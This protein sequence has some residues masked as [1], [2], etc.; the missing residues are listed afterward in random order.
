LHNC[1]FSL[2]KIITQWDILHVIIIIIIIIIIIHII[3]DIDIVMY[4]PHQRIAWAARKGR[5][6]RDTGP[7]WTAWHF[8]FQR[9]PWLTRTASIKVQ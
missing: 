2:R 7:R 8:R 3:L 6:S 5:K 1:A 4:S 9:N